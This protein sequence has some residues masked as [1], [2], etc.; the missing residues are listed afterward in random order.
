MAS[1]NSWELAALSLKRR[2]MMTDTLTFI[3]T[4]QPEGG[5][6]A[7]CTELPG[8]LTEGDSVAET[9]ENLK[10]AYKATLELM[11]DIKTMKG[12]N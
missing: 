2:G 5:Y 10:D 6:T 12:G 3:L 9:L 4:A 1:R 7:I 11:E 8:L